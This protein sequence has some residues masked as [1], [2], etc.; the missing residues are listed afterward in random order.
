MRILEG[1]YLH[2]TCILKLHDQK[3]DFPTANWPFRTRMGSTWRLH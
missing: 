3:V 1:Y 2:L